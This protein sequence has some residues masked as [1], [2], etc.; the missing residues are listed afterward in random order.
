MDMPA[1]TP[2]GDFLRITIVSETYEPEINGVAMT[3]AR[4]V[5]GL[6]DR[7][8]EVDI[9]RPRQPGQAETDEERELAVPS[10]PIPGYAAL[11]FGLPV[12]RRVRN[13]LARRRPDVVY[14]A[15]E[16]PLGASAL[17]AARAQ[18]IPV[19]SGFHTNFQQYMAHYRVGWLERP[20]RLWLRHFHRRTDLTLV[21]DPDLCRQLV[22]DGFGR[23]AVLPRGVDAERFTPAHRDA[24]LRRQWG[25]GEED[26]VAL[27]VG[28]IAPEKNL[29]LFI[30]SVRHMQAQ[31]GNV[32]GVLVGDGPLLAALR[33][34]HPDLH[35][36]GARTG[37][38]LAAHYASADLFAFP[39]LTET[40]GNVILEAM[41]SELA[42]L[43]FDYAAA[44][45]HIRHGESGLLV[46]PGDRSAFL[47]AALQLAHMQPAPLAALRQQARQRILP[48]DWQRIVARFERM[49]RH[50][51]RRPSAAPCHAPV[52]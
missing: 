25:A 46:P 50:V 28:R 18:G 51:L 2:S 17:A 21:P 5:R 48:L 19:V 26:R 15:T 32:R 31:A 22:E 43:A 44:H 12:R 36:A 20:A 4:L 10:L 16:G 49:L 47:A 14:I 27:Y 6:R 45:R 7:G 40:F 30:E 39:S 42:V 8:H 23:V 3:L 38:E 37:R 13:R 35:F 11:R 1:Q 34:R 33:R 29:D 41:A 9:I 52:I 24:E